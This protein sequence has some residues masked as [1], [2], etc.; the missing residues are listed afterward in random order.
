MKVSKLMMYFHIH[1]FNEFFQHVYE[2]N[3]I[4]HIL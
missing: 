2:V 1:C 4:M 3:V